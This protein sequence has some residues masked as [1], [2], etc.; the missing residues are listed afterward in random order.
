[1]TSRSI[2]CPAN[3]MI[4]FLFLLLNRI[5]LWIDSTFL[6]LLICWYI[7]FLALI[8]DSCDKHRNKHEYTNITM[9]YWLMALWMFTQE[10]QA[11][12]M[13]FIH[14]ILHFI[15]H[16][17]I[18]F[19]LETSV[20]I[21]R[22]VSLDC[23]LTISIKMAFSRFLPTFVGIYFLFLLS[24]HYL[25]L[26][27]GSSTH[28]YNALWFFSSSPSLIFCSPLSTSTPTHLFTSS[29]LTVTVFIYSV[30]Y[31]V[32]VELWLWV[33]SYLWY[34]MPHQWVLQAVT[35]LFQSVSAANHPAER[36]GSWWR[37]PW[38]PLN[39]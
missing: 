3:V 35:V 2:Y 22:V 24:K 9:I 4:S 5:Q 23:I 12:Y 31:W 36:P 14:F 34:L 29:F 38:S 7:F 11:R 6:N 33:L 37:P 28:D 25:N 30:T 21:S 18:H 1:M 32:R 8:P 13:T 27:F 16:F 20:L 10:W 26:S 39:S 17:I 15:T 19:I